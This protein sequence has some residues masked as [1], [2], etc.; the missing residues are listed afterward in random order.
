[1]ELYWLPG[2]K[3]NKIKLCEKPRN[4]RP[5]ASCSIHQAAPDIQ[6][7][8]HGMARAFGE[9]TTYNSIEARLHHFRQLADVLRDEAN[10]RDIAAI[11]HNAGHNNAPGKSVSSTPRA[12]RGARGG[13]TKNAPKSKRGRNYHHS[14]TPTKRKTEPG[15]CQ[16]FRPGRLC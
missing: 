14:Q 12:P 4:G 8:Y 7:N 16:S 10:S 9:E 11:P 13:I 2:R 6:L 15:N 5:A 3:R 1:M